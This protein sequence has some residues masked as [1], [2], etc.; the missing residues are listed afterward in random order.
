M[1]KKKD[2][3]AGKFGGGRN[4]VGRS[5]EKKNKTSEKI[6]KFRTFSETI[7]PVYR[8]KT[9]RKFSEMS[10]NYFLLP[11]FRSCDFLL[12]VEKKKVHST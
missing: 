1:Q 4:T 8:R 11:K 3:S 10:V 5:E 9:D 7:F 2:V 6:D 12:R